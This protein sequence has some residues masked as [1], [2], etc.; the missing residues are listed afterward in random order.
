MHLIFG[1]PAIFS[2]VISVTPAIA[3][4]T[5]YSGQH[6]AGT[7]AVA[8]AFTKETG[9]KVVVKRGSTE[10]FAGQLAEE[11]NESPADVF[12]SEQIPPLLALAEKGLL[13]PLNASLIAQTNGQG[14][15]FVPK[16]AGRDWVATSGRARVVVYDPKQIAESKLAASILDYSRPEWK[17]RIGYVPT[18]GA[19][20]EQVIA[21]TKLKGEEAARSWLTGLKENGKLYAR[22]SVALK[23]VEA[24]E[25]PAALINN[26]Y[27]YNMLREQGSLDKVRSRLHFIGHEDPGAMI[28]YAGIGVVKASVNKEEANK[29]VEFVVSKNGQQVFSNVRA[30]Y[31][32][33]SDVKSPFGMMPY[34]E[35][36]APVVPA[37]TF[38]DREAALKL[39]EEVGLK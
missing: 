5:I 31:P 6:E 23:A 21:I 24:G 4:V 13:A 34:T 25:L 16:A 19:F 1:L 12:W 17:G 10:Q 35:L 20:L 18:S 36:E 14:F 38:L 7:K 32:L 2:V 27:W 28:T 30:E 39:L 26:Y 3:D 15:K 37:T 29:F 8:S 11:G 9:I 33:R 22:N